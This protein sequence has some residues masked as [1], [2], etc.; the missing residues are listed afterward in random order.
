[1]TLSYKHLSQLS[2]TLFTFVSEDF[3]IDST[4][5]RL[6]SRL[7]LNDRRAFLR[8]VSKYKQRVKILSDA[9][10]QNVH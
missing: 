6:V 8:V 2:Q 4:T 7:E 5:T 9:T 3:V 10:K 1:M